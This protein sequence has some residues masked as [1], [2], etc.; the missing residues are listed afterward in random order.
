[1]VRLCRVAGS[2]RTVGMVLAMEYGDK[3]LCEILPELLGGEDSPLRECAAGFV[4]GRFQ[5]AGWAWVDGL[6]PETWLPVTASRLL[7]VLPFDRDTWDRAER[8]GSAVAE[9]YWDTVKSPIKPQLHCA[10]VE[11]AVAKLLERRRPEVTLDLLA[12]ALHGKEPVASEWLLRPLEQGAALSGDKLK[13]FL[14]VRDHG[15]SLFTEL[16]A[17]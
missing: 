6:H 1:M 4:W 15:E 17:K 16:Q 11:H 14:T 2:P 10:D 9:R 8:F 5:T 3:Y 7:A 13:H 12:M